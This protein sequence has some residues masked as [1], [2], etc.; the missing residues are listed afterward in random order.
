MS[1]EGPRP[2]KAARASAICLLVAF[3]SIALAAEK[4]LKQSQIEGLLNGGVASQRIAALVK[5]RGIDFK[6]TSEVL[7]KLKKDGAEPPLL[8]ALKSVKAKG[9]MQEAPSG[10]P[11]YKAQNER[12]AGK[13]L[14]DQG[15]W[16]QAE[17][18]LRG[19]AQLNPTDA[20]THFYLGLALGRQGK[21]DDSIAQYREAI[22]L[23]PDSAPAHFDLGNELMKKHDPE[24]AIHQYREALG[25]KPD[26]P[27]AYYALGTALYEQGDNAGA[28]AEFR[29]A[30]GLKSVNEKAH[31]AL[32][33]ALA[34]QKDL[35]GAIH[36]YR[37]ALETKPSDAVV[38]ADLA[39][40]LLAQGNGQQALEE[41]RIAA[42]LAP[43]NAGYHA[44]YEKLAGQLD[45]QDAR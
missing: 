4:P 32:G 40:A 45:P 43:G 42:S 34:K 17:T 12:V 30:L 6:P 22:L 36:E 29:A 15:L 27:D 25:L 14:L 28:A 10:D 23:S 35:T 26:D 7:Q 33:L 37:L 38:H 9:F 21:L 3:A 13:R 19:S 8:D 2:R 11:W 1:P 18:A 39:S 41:L 31:L 44:S 20:A 24:G 5:R 16:A